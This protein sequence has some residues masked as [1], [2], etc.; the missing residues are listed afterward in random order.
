MTPID[1]Q[2][3]MSKVRIEG[4]AYS[5]YVGEGGISVL[6]TSI[7]RTGVWKKILYYSSENDNSLNLKVKIEL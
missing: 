1:I 2:V 7:F 6:Q 5:L 4:Q 3:T